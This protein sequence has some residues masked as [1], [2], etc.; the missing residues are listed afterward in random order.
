MVGLGLFLPWWCPLL[1]PVAL[2][3]AGILLIADCIK[4]SF[5]PLGVAP[6]SCVIGL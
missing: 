6:C 3:F 5:G 4:Y 1:R 2:G